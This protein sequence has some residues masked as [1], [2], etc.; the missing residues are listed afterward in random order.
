MNLEVYDLFAGPVGS[1]VI[2][3][4]GKPAS[5]VPYDG[6]PAYES[7]TGALLVMECLLCFTGH[8][9][10]SRF[11]M[12]LPRSYGIVSLRAP[13]GL[14]ALHDDPDAIWSWRPLLYQ[15]KFYETQRYGSQQ[16]LEWRIGLQ[17]ARLSTS[18]FD[19][20]QDRILVAQA[21]EMKKRYGRM[22]PITLQPGQ[23]GFR[24]PKNARKRAYR[25]YAAALDAWEPP[26]LPFVE[27]NE[28]A[29]RILREHLNPQQRL[30]LASRHYFYVRGT[31]NRLY[32]I[33]PGNGASIVDP[34]THTVLVSLCLHP[35]EW[36]PHDDVALATKL[37]IES[38]PAGEEEMLAGARARPIHARPRPRSEE[39]R[40]WRMERELLPAQLP[41]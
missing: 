37:L 18:E 11:P 16:E 9:A 36:I 35:D 24:L 6:L 33:E 22:P 20:F 38:G 17:Q 23:T 1:R 15:L 25:E 19:D 28:R 31:I 8:A 13:S 2:A 7:E 27:A 32:R 10:A 39:K 3:R 14:T 26:E 21:A 34:E 12:L 41:A 5:C 40:A 30:E 29:A 4:G